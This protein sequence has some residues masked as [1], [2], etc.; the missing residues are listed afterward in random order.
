MR[1]L[2][3][4]AGIAAAAY[5]FGY[6]IEN[7]PKINKIDSIKKIANKS[8]LFGKANGYVVVQ[9]FMKHYDIDPSILN[10]V[11]DSIC[12]NEIKVTFIEK[13]PLLLKEHND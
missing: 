3:I 8:K 2:K 12:D 7:L 13:E 11:Y 10:S 9:D 1:Q 4:K 5:L 6:G